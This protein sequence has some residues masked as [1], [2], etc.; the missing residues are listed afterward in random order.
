MLNSCRQQEFATMDQ[1]EIEKQAVIY[2]AQ[3]VAGLKKI[4][5][6]GEYF[7]EE[8]RQKWLDQLRVSYINAA[9][10]VERPRLREEDLFPQPK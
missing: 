9:N 6:D 3:M 8:Q 10:G 4:G 5:V 2:Q 7:C 1:K